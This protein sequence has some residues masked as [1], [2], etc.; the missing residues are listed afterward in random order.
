MSQTLP[1]TNSPTPAGHLKVVDHDGDRDRKLAPFDYSQLD[2]DLA[3]RAR[4]SA[5]RINRW[6]R[7]TVIA[8]GNELLEMKEALGHGH[9]GDWI[10]REVKFSPASARNYMAVAREFGAVPLITSVLPLSTVYRL[11]GTSAT[12]RSAVVAQ[13]EAGER[14]DPDAVQKLMKDH[15]AKVAREKKS[16]KKRAEEEAAEKRRL[17][18]EAAAKRHHDQA[19]EEYRRSEATMIAETIPII[20]RWNATEDELLKVGNI[21][22]LVSMKRIMEHLAT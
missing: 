2:D 22:R 6:R 4:T 17:R 14:V 11:A 12:V 15:K 5:E 1:E 20:R 9:F 16:L 10:V 21:L 3:A 19:Q 7:D 13:V 18:R 8:V